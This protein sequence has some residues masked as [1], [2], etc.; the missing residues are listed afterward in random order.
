VANHGA[1][2]FLIIILISL[3][4]ISVHTKNVPFIVS[5]IMAALSHGKPPSAGISRDIYGAQKQ[6]KE[7]ASHI[8]IHSCTLSPNINI[9]S[10]V[11]RP[12]NR[13]SVPDRPRDFLYSKV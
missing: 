7:R 4:F 2:R 6:T 11:G 10:Q 12:R 8:C 5:P 9:M 1:V 13:G 3:I